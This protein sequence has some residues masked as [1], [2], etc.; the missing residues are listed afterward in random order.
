MKTSHDFD[1]IID[2]FVINDYTNVIIGQ[3]SNTT[4]KNCIFNRITNGVFNCNLDNC[5]IN[6]SNVIIQ[7]NINNIKNISKSENE[8]FNFDCRGNI[9]NSTFDLNGNFSSNEN[10]SITNCLLK[11]KGQSD[12]HS[13]N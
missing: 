6:N 11:I 12:I 13:L 7:G 3:L 9:T 4:F 5:A 10:Y 2:G 8:I 1:S